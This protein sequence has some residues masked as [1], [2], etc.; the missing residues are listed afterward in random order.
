MKGRK[1]ADNIKLAMGVPGAELASHLDG[2]RPR[3]LCRGPGIAWRMEV[4]APACRV[5]G[6][7]VGERVLIDFSIC[8]RDDDSLAGDEDLDFLGN[9]VRVQPNPPHDP[10][11]RRAAVYG[12]VVVVLSL[13]S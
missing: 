7:R 13:V 4:R 8:A 3:V 9:V 5:A 1:V 6:S 10:L 2:A 11:H 12:S